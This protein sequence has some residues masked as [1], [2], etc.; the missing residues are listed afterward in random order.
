MGRWGLLLRDGRGRARE[1]EEGRGPTSK[2]R[3]RVG[4][5]EKG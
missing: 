2:A 3:G 4:R 1:G 5:G